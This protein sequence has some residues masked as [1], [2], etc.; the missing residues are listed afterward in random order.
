MRTG[1]GRG[2]DMRGAF[3][4]DNEDGYAAIIAAL[5]LL[6]LISIVS[7]MG[8]RVASTEVT[9][10]GN[11]TVYQRNFYLAEGAVMEAVDRLDNTAS[12]KSA[13]FPWLE[14]VAKKLETE[15]VKNVWD[16]ASDPSE[17]L[18]PETAAID[19]DHAMYV[20]GLEGVAPGFSARD[21]QPTVHLFHIFGRTVW[22]GVSTIQVGYL[23]P[24]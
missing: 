18:I 1:A 14:T 8:S 5:A 17:T 22:N 13:A 6:V 3:R 12:I 20:A 4:I 2:F 16:N 11:E 10:A 23:A 24:Y 9:M 21:G 19:P 7:I 15:N